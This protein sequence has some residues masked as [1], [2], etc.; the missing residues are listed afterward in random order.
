MKK[1]NLFLIAFAIASFLISCGGPS[2]S[3]LDKALNDLNKLSENLDSL[4]KI[5]NVTADD[6]TTSSSDDK[7][8]SKDGHFKINFAGEPE[9]S[10]EPIPTEIGN[11]QMYMYTYEKSATEVEM[12]AY[13]D[14][15][16]EMIKAS[17]P[18]DLLIG[19][20]NGAINNLGATI[21]KEEK[22]DF[23]GNPGYQF[24]ADNGSYYVDYKIFLKGNRLYQIAIMRDGSA[25]TEEAVKNFIGSFELTD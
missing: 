18:D 2:S 21:T 24:K 6:E 11:I 4:D 7:F 5:D 9:V 17:N 12:L 19:A 14:Y 15:P 23:D 1:F 8:Y 16:S 20:K 22:I 25:P 13:S 3:D 10:N